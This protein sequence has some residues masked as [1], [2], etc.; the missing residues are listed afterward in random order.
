M[1]IIPL[2]DICSPKPSAEMV[3]QP[4]VS[5][6]NPSGCPAEGTILLT[7]WPGEGI[8]PG[9]ASL[10]PREVVPSRR[11]RPPSLARAGAPVL[12]ATLPVRP[13]KAESPGLPATSA[14]SRKRWPGKAEGKVPRGGRRKRPERGAGGSYLGPQTPWRG[15]AGSAPV[16]AQPLSASGGEGGSARGLRGLRGGRPGARGAP[17]SLKHARGLPWPRRLRAARELRA[18]RLPAPGS[19]RGGVGAARRSGLLERERDFL[20]RA[21]CL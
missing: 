12:P 18:S 7:G 9:D 8:P 16:S 13:G 17:S 2:N 15:G 11:P 5:S 1:M 14:G 19:R 20:P 10:P 6:E 21:P 4:A 3:K